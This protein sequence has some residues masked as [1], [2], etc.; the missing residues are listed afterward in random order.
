[1]EATAGRYSDALSAE[2]APDERANVLSL[3]KGNEGAPEKPEEPLALPGDIKAAE[4][5]LEAFPICLQAYIEEAARSLVCPRDFVAIP[6]LVTA[7]A[8]IGRALRLEIKPDWHEHG[9]LYAGIVG[10]PGDKKSPALA[11]GTR[12]INRLARKMLEDHREIRDQYEA[13]LADYEIEVTKWK[14]AALSDKKGNTGDK[15]TK[16][17]EPPCPRLCIGD[18]T[19]ESIAEILEVNPRG[20]LVSRDELSAWAR[21]F[22]QYKSGKGADKEFWLS[23]WAGA[24]AHVDRKGRKPILIFNPFLA[25]VGC[26]PPDIIPELKDEQNRADGF[27][28]RVLFSYPESVPQRWSDAV[29]SEEAIREMD[30]CFD[31]LMALPFQ[32]HEPATLYL[33]QGARELLIDWTNAH[34]DEMQADLF[35]YILRGPW[36]KM[37]GQMARIT[38]IIHACRL[39]SGETTS[40]LVDEISVS[41]GIALT[42]YFK[43]HARKVYNVLD[44]THKERK[45]IQ[46]MN[47]IEKAQKNEVTPRDIQMNHVAG[48]KSAE[49]AR[50]LLNFLEEYG[51]GHWDEAK[52]IFYI[53]Y[54]TQQ[55]N[56]QE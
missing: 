6:L 35:P 29:I 14:K 37:P 20:V 48:C 16:P 27:M 19:V 23:C 9:A 13:E 10:Q 7:G 39:V 25:V 11:K 53:L 31:G 56:K 12:S 33:A 8:T 54:T 40:R 30:A 42:E 4:L 55:C 21:S 52:K 34:F 50:E 28:D 24:P 46:L 41:S 51:Q 15:P 43:D 2:F 17:E 32:D 1:M 3:A 49:D 22:N 26:I 38:L 36:G 44:L 47:W 18:A 5:P 45:V